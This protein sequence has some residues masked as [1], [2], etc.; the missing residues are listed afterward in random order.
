MPYGWLCFIREVKA[1]VLIKKTILLSHKNDLVL[2]YQSGKVGSVSFVN[3]IDGLSNVTCLHVHRINREHIRSRRMIAKSKGWRYEAGD[4]NGFA[5]YPYLN[6]FSSIKMICPI[7][8]PISANASAFFQNIT[9]MK[10]VDF[11]NLSDINKEKYFI[12]HWTHLDADEWFDKELKSIA[13]IDVYASSFD[14]HAG[15]KVFKNK[16]FECLVLYHDLPDEVKSEITS[17]FLGKEVRIRHEHSS[18]DKAYA[19]DYKKV[20]KEVLEDEEY[21]RNMRSQRY[22]QHFYKNRQSASSL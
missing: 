20:L 6:R 12:E 18:A 21:C 5:L 22:Y 16:N 8:E 10:T 2:I 3:A 17:N 14:V 7:R 13:G 15:Y 11:Y 4:E 9:R 1:W 19:S